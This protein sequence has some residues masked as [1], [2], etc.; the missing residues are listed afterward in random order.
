MMDAVAFWRLHTGRIILIIT[1]QC[2]S[3]AFLHTIRF[4][5]LF[6]TEHRWQL[7]LAWIGL[8]IRNRVASSI[9]GCLSFYR[10]FYG[11]PAAIWC[12][13]VTLNWL[14]RGVSSSS[15][16]IQLGSYFCNLVSFRAYADWSFS[17]R[18]C[19]LSRKVVLFLY[20]H[21]LYRRKY[22]TAT[23]ALGK[24]VS[25]TVDCVIGQHLLVQS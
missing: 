3:N 20:L 15:I 6:P 18:N 1:I 22:D 9:S 25:I 10:Y 13:I 19:H 17:M 7:V 8:P 23:A 5:G 11:S 12:S 4:M 14:T 2:K 16:Y 21:G 24:V